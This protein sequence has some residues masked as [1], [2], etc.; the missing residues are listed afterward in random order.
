MSLEFLLQPLPIL[1][2]MESIYI[3]P[4]TEGIYGNLVIL[5]QPYFQDVL[6]SR[7]APGQLPSQQV[8]KSNSALSPTC[9]FIKHPNCYW[10]LIFPFR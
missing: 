5:H 9:L 2:G 1:V 7:L 8:P 3:Q 4:V 6:I 10:F